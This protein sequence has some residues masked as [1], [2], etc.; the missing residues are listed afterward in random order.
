MPDLPLA[1][2]PLPNGKYR[3]RA[4]SG[5][6][7]EVQADVEAP[8]TPQEVSEITELLGHRKPGLMRMEET[9]A[10]RQFGQKLF[11]FLIKDNPGIY[12]AYRMGVGRG[13]L[14]LRLSVEQAGTLAHLPWELLR[15]PERD[16]LALADST[17]IVRASPQL[18]IRPPVPLVL[19]LRILVL[20][21]E[22]EWQRLQQTLAVLQSRDQIQLDR[23]DKPTL[24][25]LRLRMLAEDYQILHLIVPGAMD[26]E[27]EESFL[28]MNDDG[29]ARVSSDDLSQEI[30]PESTVR[31]VVLSS[32]QPHKRALV[33]YAGT[34]NVP[35]VVTTQFLMQ[36]DSL[37]H[38]ELYRALVEGSPIDM[39]MSRARRAIANHMANNDWAAP[40]LFLHSDSARLFRS[41][42]AGE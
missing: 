6:S 13:S 28:L 32:A 23:L 30:Y 39:A 36:T 14:R 1:F 24:R 2:E 8:F 41:L 34:L 19:P 3:I 38:A 15:D 40:L 35:A 10:A 17:P 16:F 18:S 31:L 22:Q 27:T 5:T 21:A 29:L 7:G 20:A 26:K 4:N 37:L 12:T 9:R 33:Q 25:G 11:N 42:A